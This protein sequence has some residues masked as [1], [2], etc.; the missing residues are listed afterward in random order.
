MKKS[1]LFLLVLCSSFLMK[2][3]VKA[4]SIKDST[5]FTMPV[6]V[7][8]WTDNDGKPRK[9][10]MVKDSYSSKTGVCVLIKYYDGTT[11]VSI[12]STLMQLLRGIQVLV[13]PFTIT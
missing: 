11:P 7:I 2:Q 13:V 5:A 3:N 10:A 8:D 12:Q 1:I 4:L 9:V 6:F